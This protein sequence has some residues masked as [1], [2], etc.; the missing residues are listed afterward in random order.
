MKFS[1][2]KRTTLEIKCDQK[3]EPLARSPTI[4]NI[5]EHTFFFNLSKTHKKESFR[6]ELRNFSSV[7]ML[8]SQYN[9]IL[10]QMIFLLFRSLFFVLGFSHWNSED[11]LTIKYIIAGVIKTVVFQIM[12]SAIKLTRGG[13]FKFIFCCLPKC[14]SLPDINQKVTSYVRVPDFTQGDKERTVSSMLR[15]VSYLTYNLGSN[16]LVTLLNY[17]LTA[18]E[19]ASFTRE[20][21]LKFGINP[22]WILFASFCFATQS[23]SLYKMAVI[24]DDEPKKKKD[25]ILKDD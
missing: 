11:G 18:C 20:F 2:Y 7:M 23:F 12:Y 13:F 25:V 8:T 22:L 14:C 1:A 9:D 4:S 24:F 3:V 21:K 5:L 16:Y 6:F 17:G 15:S 19:V 10:A